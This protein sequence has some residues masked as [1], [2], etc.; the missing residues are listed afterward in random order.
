M[1]DY[2]LSLLSYPCLDRITSEWVNSQ[3]IDK[4]EQIAKEWTEIY[5][6]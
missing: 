4:F 3:N 5:A 6:T 2:I 1:L